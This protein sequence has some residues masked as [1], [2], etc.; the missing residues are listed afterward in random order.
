MYHAA[1]A[2]P[3]SGPR[4]TDM[5]TK[6]SSQRRLL[7]PSEM[8]CGNHCAFHESMRKPRDWNAFVGKRG[9]HRSFE[10]PVYSLSSPSSVSPTIY[11]GISNSVMQL[12]I[13]SVLDQHPDPIYNTEPLPTESA[14]KK[15]LSASTPAIASVKLKSFTEAA[16]KRW[17]PENNVMNIP[18]YEQT[19][20]V[21]SNPSCEFLPNSMCLN[22]QCISSGVGLVPPR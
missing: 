18:M 20:Q 5:T 4:L 6:S 8:G 19:E 13:V 9:P 11:A 15:P 12:D 1:D 2:M 7:E 21:K 17:D 14:Y 22:V 16:A 10:S 3:C